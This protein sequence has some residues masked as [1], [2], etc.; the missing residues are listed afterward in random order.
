MLNLNIKTPLYAAAALILMLAWACQT[1]NFT[2]PP[3]PFEVQRLE[4][5]NVAFQFG[6][7]P[8]SFRIRTNAQNVTVTDKGNIRIRGTLFADRSN[9][10]PVKFS[11]GDFILIKNAEPSMKSAHIDGIG[12]VP[13]S[14]GSF[15]MLT[16]TGEEYT[17]FTAFGGYSE[18]TIPQVGILQEATVDQPEGTNILFAKGSDLPEGFPVNSDRTYYYFYYDDLVSFALGQAPFMIDRMAIDPD[19]PYLYVHAN[20]MSIPGLESLED[21]GFAVSVQGNIPFIPQESLSFG[22]VESFDY[23]NLLLQGSINLQSVFKVPIVIADA[24]CVIGFGNLENGVNFFNGADVPMMMGLQGGFVLAVHDLANFTLGE[25][26]VSL[27]IAGYS[28]FEFSWAGWITNEIRVLE[29]IEE[30][31]GFNTEGSA[32]DFFQIPGQVNEM[33]TWGTIGTD[34]GNWAFGFESQSYL[35]IPNIMKFDM[36]GI[37]FD[38]SPSNLDLYCRMRIGGFGFVNF[39]GYIHDDGAF[40]IEAHAGSDVSFDLK[41]LEIE[42]GYRVGFDFDANVNGDWSFCLDGKAYLDISL[43]EPFFV[44]HPELIEYRHPDGRP[45]KLEIS[46]GIDACLNNDG[47]FKGKVSFSF[48][49]IGYSFKFSFSLNSAESNPLYD[50]QEIPYE[51]VPL[52]NR[53]GPEVIVN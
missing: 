25:A 42:C 48:L 38:L 23:G 1:E 21:G 50:F 13:L 7:G 11:Q 24:T 52:E 29:P 33:K 40:G 51:E 34:P 17:E 31:L 3:D 9:Q 12:D 32:W 16:A 36:G 2:E 14:H 6:E 8:G 49:K 20:A 19:D 10:A 28:D 41:I 26:A 37:T 47:K 43:G 18:F 4:D 5:G 35:N 15:K 46:V 53:F 22:R 39:G 27:R 45:L 30:L 44:A